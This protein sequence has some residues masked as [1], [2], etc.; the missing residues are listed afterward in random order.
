MFQQLHNG[1]GYIP[2]MEQVISQLERGTLVTK[3]SWR[4]KPESKTLSIRRETRQLMWTRPTT[5][6]SKLHYEGRLIFNNNYVSICN[7]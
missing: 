2:E 6:T 4:K 3:F 1:T 5:S 7:F